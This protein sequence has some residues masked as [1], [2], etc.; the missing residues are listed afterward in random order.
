MI[1]GPAHIHIHHCFHAVGH[2]TFLTGVV[3]CTGHPTF[4]W[5]YDCG[6]KRP[7]RVAAALEGLGSWENHTSAW[8]PW[9]ADAAIDMV[10]VSHFDDDHVNGLEGL[11]TSHRVK[12]LVLPYIGLKQR[13]EHAASLSGGDTS[14][15]STAAFAIDPL[16]FLAARGLSG[17]VEQLLLIVGGGETA[18]DGADPMPLVPR[19]DSGEVSALP[20]EADL[21][22]D[23]YLRGPT[24]LPGTG[25]SPYLRPHPHS[26][27][28]SADP[29]PLEFVFYN[30]ALPAGR[31]NRSKKPLSEI[32]IEVGEIASRYRLLD[33]SQR[34]RR[35]W[36]DALKACYTKHFGN[37]GKERNNISL[38]VLVRPM[39][40][41]GIG[42][43]NF[44]PEP[45][46]AWTEAAM[47]SIE[48]QPPNI[49]LTGDLSIDASE[50]AQMHAH[51][52]G[53][54]W[55]ELGVV[56]VPHHGSRHSWQAGNAAKFPSP[57]FVL[58]VPTDPGKGHHPH[59]SVLA[60]ISTCPSRRAD[61]DW[62]VTQTYHFLV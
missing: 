13:L 57:L 41:D 58:C 18:G 4:R 60:D 50:L 5:T 28:L 55:N 24:E 49:L 23:G 37:S 16:G 46:V 31:A 1:A 7:T 48:D 35:G 14:S 26:R 11:L 19:P 29:L 6:S 8:K 54:R 2:G 52:G 61:Y 17:Q 59:A 33:A 27:P 21:T 51:F 43:C 30:T 47:A 10:V 42:P 38:C 25:A 36:R 15:A 56:Q 62:A 32:A 22:S 3:H 44:F 20:R 40:T 34:P 9:P 12:L 53:W 39:S 45:P